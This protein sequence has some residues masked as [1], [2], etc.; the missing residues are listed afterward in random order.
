MSKP[1]TEEWD[2]KDQNFC[3]EIGMLVALS[4]VYFLEVSVHVAL[5]VVIKDYFRDRQTIKI[6]LFT[7]F[8]KRKKGIVRPKKS[9]INL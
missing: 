2:Q 7:L 8:F 4:E 6:E 5:K 3:D 9:K 1:K